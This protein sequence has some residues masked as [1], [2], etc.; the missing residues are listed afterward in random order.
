MA[1]F[2]RT[3]SD[4]Q[5][6]KQPGQVARPASPDEPRKATQRAFDEARV[7]HPELSSARALCQRF[8]LSWSQLLRAAT[9]PPAQQTRQASY[10]RRD[11]S[12]KGITVEDCVDAIRR[13][14]VKNKRKRLT[15]SDYQALRDK[16][17]SASGRSKAGARPSLPTVNQVD[18]ILA[19]EGVSWTQ[20][21]T[22]AGFNP[23]PEPRQPGKTRAKRWTPDEILAGLQRADQR[24]G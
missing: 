2:A 18:R 9:A 10:G 5:A 6:L 13:V 14:A 11:S 22:Q 8:G 23:R 21:V 20:A 12:R 15:R 17:T 1:R 3:L 16:M 19:K 7:D 24:L 4:E